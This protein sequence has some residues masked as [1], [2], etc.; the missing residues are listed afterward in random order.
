M[1]QRLTSNTGESAGPHL[2][3]SLMELK[4]PHNDGRKGERV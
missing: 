3:M 2:P 4:A 1:A